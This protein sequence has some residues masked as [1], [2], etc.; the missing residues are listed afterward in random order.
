MYR[1]GGFQRVNGIDPLSAA[2]AWSVDFQGTP[3]LYGYQSERLARNIMHSAD[4]LRK[5][6]GWM[7]G[8]TV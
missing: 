5:N 6:W 4:F 1:I 2:S 7:I 8:H 3:G